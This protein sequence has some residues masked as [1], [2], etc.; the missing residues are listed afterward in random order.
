MAAT[1]AAKPAPPPDFVSQEIS[2]LPNV[3][4]PRQSRTVRLASASLRSVHDL[5]AVP[6]FQIVAGAAILGLIAVLLM[7]APTAPAVTKVTAA[8][9][10]PAGQWQTATLPKFPQVTVTV[11]SYVQPSR[12]PAMPVGKPPAAVSPPR[13]RAPEE[14]RALMT[15]IRAF[16]SGT[17]KL[18]NDSDYT[19][20]LAGL[21]GLPRFADAEKAKSALTRAKA[22][23]QAMLPYKGLFPLPASTP[24]SLLALLT[25]VDVVFITDSLTA[26]LV[27]D[28]AL[29]TLSSTLSADG[30]VVNGRTQGY[31]RMGS[32]GA[33]LS[34]DLTFTRAAYSASIHADACRTSRGWKFQRASQH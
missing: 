9:P 18:R 17:S 4:A 2:R 3:V 7:Q 26:M 1:D 13:T 6:A 14:D 29:H 16:H 15:A 10:P 22:K 27:Q 25:P 32:G 12:L 23:A 28:S 8:P 20:S 11:P 21:L 19:E 34:Y 30:A 33:C 31:W 5:V 24:V